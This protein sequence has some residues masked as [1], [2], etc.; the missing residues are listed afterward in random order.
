MD[1]PAEPGAV[2]EYRYSGV[3]NAQRHGPRPSFTKHT[4]DTKLTKTK[5]DFFVGSVRFVVFVLK[6]R[7]PVY[8]SGT[9]PL[10]S[11]LPC[12]KLPP[13][14]SQFRVGGAFLLHY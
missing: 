2:Q 8:S 13:C 10:P 11:N 6:S 4:K 7:Q 9:Y 3:L 5:M 14:V 1:E 12:G